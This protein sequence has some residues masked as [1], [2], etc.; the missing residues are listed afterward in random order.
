MKTSGRF[1]RPWITRRCLSGSMSGVAGVRDHE[2]QAVGRDRAVEQVVRR[3]RVLGARLAVGIAERAHD[4]FLE[5]RPHAV[6]RD[7]GAGLE[8][9]R[10]V[11]E[12]L[13]GCRFAMRITRHG[14]R[15]R[16]A[17]AQKSAAVKQSVAGDCLHIFPFFALFDCLAS[18]P[19]CPP[20][21]IGD[22]NARS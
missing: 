15:E 5:P 13:G 8:A 6:I 4:V 22:R 11:R 12:R 9:P 2:V 20:R 18:F 3:A 14:R 17:A 16:G 21:V 19:C 1:T 7:E 10:I